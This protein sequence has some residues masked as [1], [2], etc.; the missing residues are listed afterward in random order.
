[1]R[2][3]VALFRLLMQARPGVIS[4]LSEDKKEHLVTANEALDE[5]RLIIL[6]YLHYCETE[7]TF[8]SPR[9]PRKSR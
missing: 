4:I 7:L 5:E 8:R 2:L 6:H 1:M 3:L 9:T